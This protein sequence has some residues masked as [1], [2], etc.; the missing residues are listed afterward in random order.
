MSSQNLIRYG[1]AVVIA[2]GVAGIFLLAG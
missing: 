1:P 2:I